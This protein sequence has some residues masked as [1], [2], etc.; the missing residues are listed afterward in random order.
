MSLPGS[1][2]RALRNSVALPIVNDHSHS[3]SIDIIV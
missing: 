3:Y 2:I 1:M